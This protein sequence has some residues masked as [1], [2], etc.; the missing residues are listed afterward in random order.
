MKYHVV[1]DKEK[2]IRPI[3]RGYKMACCDCGLVHRMNFKH[4][5]YGDGRKILFRAERDERA[6]AAVRRE[7]LKNPV[8]LDRFY[9]IVTKLIGEKTGE[10][11]EWNSIH[12]Q[13]L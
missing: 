7:K 10:H 11:A 12:H 1:T 5:P 13:N 8:L 4:I 2:W 6:T 3:K 9:R